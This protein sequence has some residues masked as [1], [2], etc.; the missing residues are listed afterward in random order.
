MTVTSSGVPSVYRTLAEIPEGG[1]TGDGPLLDTFGRRA[2]DLRVSLTDRCNLRC[3]YC[4]PA[5]GL[6]W[7]P[8]EQ[9]LARR[10]AHPAPAHRGH[11]AR[12]HQCPLHR[13]RAAGRRHLEE[14]VARRPRCAPPRDRHHHQ[15]VG[16]GRRAR[17]CAAGLDRVNVSLDTVD[18]AHFAAHHPPGPA[19]RRDGGPFRGHRAGL[20]PVK[21]NAVLDPTTGSRRGDAAAVLP[22][23]RLPRCASSSRCRWTPA[24]SGTAARRSPRTTCSRCCAPL[25]ADAGPAPAVPHR[26]SCG[27]STAARP[28]SA[29]SRRS[30]TSSARPATEPG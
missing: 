10:R 27:W 24:T 23:R 8:G 17:A 4:M 3:T 6:D 12:R 16:L 25:H 26:R 11:P 20:T 13:R 28:P 22:R 15:A 5:E 18:A 7:M 1:A 21:V 2:T 9:L 19:S 29:S 14:V 30:R